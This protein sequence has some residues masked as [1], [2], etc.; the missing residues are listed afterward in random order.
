MQHTPDQQFPGRG[1]NQPEPAAQKSKNGLCRVWVV[2][3][4]ILAVL[5]VGMSALVL[6][7]YLSG[8]NIRRSNAAPKLETLAPAA[9]TG[10]TAEKTTEK[11]TESSL[12]DDSTVLV[13]GTH[14]RFNDEIQTFLL[15]GIDSHI[16]AYTDGS[17]NVHAFSDAIMLAAMD[18]RNERISLIAISRDAMCE[19]Q[20]LNPDG[21][22]G[23]HVYG[24]LALSFS[25]GDGDA[26][27]CEITKD[28]VSQIMCD[29]PIASC[30]A[31]YLDGL[32]EL[33]DAVGG[34]T[35][36]ILEDIDYG[37][38]SMQQGAEVTLDG[39]MAEQ[40]IRRREH[41]EVG[42]PKRMERQ[43]Q[44]I[45]ALLKKTME[46][47]R[48]NPERILDIYNSIK[49]DV[50]T[51][52]TAGEIVYLATAAARMTVDSEIR[53]LP[54]QVRLSEDGFAQ[55]YLDEKGLLDLLLDVYY[56]P[57]E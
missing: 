37:Y 48:Q 19:F 11:T 42:N 46:T 29:L 23:D 8:K 52:L 5:A 53:S 18:F 38:A 10:E 51:D 17:C 13:N 12:R 34:V 4:C 24:Q 20:A 32:Q 7:V 27:S 1:S 45:I 3:V 50:V 35:V 49:G 44:Y 2:L 55:Y 6:H 30:S 36:T 15:L 28:A 43:K 16:P 39:P 14:Y 21:T 31:L 9:Q 41:T 25:Y 56:I 40:Y 22:E 33:N 26:K 47:V 57:C 54:G